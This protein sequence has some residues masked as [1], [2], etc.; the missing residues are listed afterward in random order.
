MW[1][2]PLLVWDLIW[3][4]LIAP[5]LKDGGLCALCILAYAIQALFFAGFCEEV[6]K[7]KV[8]S[9]ITNSA[10]TNDWRTMLVYG[11][12]AGC[13]FATAENIAYVFSGGFATAVVRAFVSVPLHCCTGAI[14][15]LEIAKRRPMPSN[16]Q[17][18]S[19]GATRHMQAAGHSNMHSIYHH[20]HNHYH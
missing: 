2:I 14:I 16:C 1:M 19:T 12:C 20:Y 18:L 11:I 7:F 3:I 6:V 9:R 4:L 5:Q 13:G 10:V 15:G 17:T 8:I